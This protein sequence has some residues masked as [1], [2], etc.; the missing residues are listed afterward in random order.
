MKFTHLD[1][2]IGKICLLH[3]ISETNTF[4]CGGKKQFLNNYF[5]IA[6]VLFGIL[7]G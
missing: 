4:S 2:A 3:F 5:S 1:L 7:T 6:K